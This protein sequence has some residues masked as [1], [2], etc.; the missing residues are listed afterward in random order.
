[1]KNFAI[2][3]VGNYA[4]N[5]IRIIQKLEKEKI[6][7]LFCAVVRDREKNK[8]AVEN[9]DYEGVVIYPSFEKMLTYGQGK[10]DIIALPIGGLDHFEYAKQAMEEGYDVV[11]EKP[12]AITI[13][14]VNELQKLREKVDQYCII[15]NELLFS[16]SIGLLCN[17]IGSGRLGKL[18]SIKAKCAW[19]CGSDYF[20]RNNWA[21]RLV[22]DGKWNLDG[23]ATNHCASVLTSA[24]YLLQSACEPQT[25]IE[26][27]QAELYRAYDITSYD[28][29]SMR[30]NM[31]NGTNVHFVSS[32][33]VENEIEPVMEIICEDATI[34]WQANEEKTII[35]FN[36]GKKK[37]FRERQAE[38]KFESIFR[39]AITVTTTRTRRPNSSIKTSRSHVL[40]LNLAFESAEEIVT[41]P[42]EFLAKSTLKGNKRIFMK[43]ADSILANAYENGKLF[44]ELDLPWAKATTAYPANNYSNFPLNP[45]LKKL[46]S[47]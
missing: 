33:A 45:K 29:V 10:I 16:S 6:A 22:V 5:Y 27:V 13:Q 7:N 11:V 23:P 26:S 20:A 39:E 3:G 38:T 21:G 15:G 18:K 19:P 40:A 41:I 32:Y 43:D 1:M 9:L 24:L 46:I 37:I 30:V 28:T 31:D 12:A 47:E 34:K 36:T 25:E 2:V 17:E 4:D 35:R 14:D 8:K 42:N 44:S